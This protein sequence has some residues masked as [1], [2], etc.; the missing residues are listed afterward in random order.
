[1]SGWEVPV[2]IASAL[3]SQGPMLLVLL[4]GIVV[5]LIRGRRHPLVSAVVALGCGVLLLEQIAIAA[6]YVILPLYMT[7]WS[8]YQPFSTTGGWDYVF[9]VRVMGILQSV[10]YA[11]GVAL[12]VVST[13]V[14]R[15]DESADAV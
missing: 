11:L 9:V 13:M 2:A 1:M 15:C 4:G 10:L 8:N 7:R 5:A 12:L 3:A 6:V 14:A